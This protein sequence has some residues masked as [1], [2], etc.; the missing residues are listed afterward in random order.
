MLVLDPCMGSGT[1]GLAAKNLN[2]D[3]I[4]IEKDTELGYFEAAKNRIG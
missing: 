3:F 2:R 1:C 4:G